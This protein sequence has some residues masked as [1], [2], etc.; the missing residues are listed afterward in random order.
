MTERF[1]ELV[2]RPETE[3][4]LDETVL[5]IAGH[6]H[7]DLDVDLRLRELDA[8]AAAVPTAPGRD[9]P[10]RLAHHLFVDLGFAG[11]RGDYADPE[12]SYLDAV[13]D[14]RLGIPITLSVLMLEVGR[15]ID[16]PLRGVGMPGH[17]LVGGGAGEW[18]DP[19]N[20]GERLDLN[21]C[22]Q[23]FA[24]TQNAAAFRPQHLRPVGPLRIVERMLAN[25]QHATM[26]DKSPDAVWITRLRL[27]IP[28]ISLSL[29]GQLA[30]V[31]GN[32]GHF[33]EAA[34]ELDVLARQLPGDGGRQAAEA[35]TRFRARTN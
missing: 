34:R 15:R 21:G 4:P 24:Q 35:A 29:R 18:F 28:D 23:R 7:P 13:L 3:I 20:G 22:A 25:L 12:N 9:A 1:T 5:V 8:L 30:G 19:F 11:N 31:L 27:R 26:R 33:G 2:N 32:Y 10:A 17:F 14:R 6:A 16:V